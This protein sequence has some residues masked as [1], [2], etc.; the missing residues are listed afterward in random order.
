MYD[1]GAS[2]GLLQKIYEDEA[3]TQRPIILE[4]RDEAIAVSKENWTQ[5]LGNQRYVEGP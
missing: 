4:P 3:R 5:Y 2:A 1:L